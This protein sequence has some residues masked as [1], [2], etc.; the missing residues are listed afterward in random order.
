[1]EQ[2]MEQL[3]PYVHWRIIPF[4]DTD[5]AAIV[6]T[7]R[8]SDYCMEAA[9]VWFRDVIDFDWFQ[10][11]TERGMG[12]PVV[13]MDIDFK[14]PLK[15]GDKLAVEVNVVKIG[16]STVTLQLKGKRKDKETNEMISSFIGN[17]I[18]CFTSIEKKGAIAIPDIQRKYIEDYVKNCKLNA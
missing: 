12:S 1:M 15:G 10:I 4:G 16:R 18:F 11:N 5:A 6:Y 8:F 9:E 14:G 3:K 2:K 13:H 17:F 7:P